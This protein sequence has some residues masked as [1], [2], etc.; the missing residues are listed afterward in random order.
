MARLTFDAVQDYASECG[1]TIEKKSKGYLLNGAVVPT[2]ARIIEVIKNGDLLNSECELLPV[3]ESQEITPKAVAKAL[4]YLNNQTQ[5]EENMKTLYIVRGCPGDGK[6]TLAHRLVDSIVAVAADDM[7]GLYVDGKYQQHLQ[8]QSHEWCM[9][10]IEG[11]MRGNIEEMAVHN[12]FTRIF[13]IK[14]Y[15]ELANKYG[16]SVHIIHSEAVLTAGGRTTD[17]H[18]VPLDVLASMRNG[19]E[20]WDT[21]PKLGITAKDIAEQ[22][23]KAK[24]YPDCIIF[25]MDGTIK[26]TKSGGA[27]PQTPDDF[28]ITKEFDDFINIHF[29]RIQQID[30]YIVSNQRG[31]SGGQKTEEFL[32]KEVTCLIEHLDIHY[33]SSPTKSYF[34]SKDYV[35]ARSWDEGRDKFYGN[36][37]KPSPAVFDLIHN[38]IQSN[39]TRRNYWII[40]DA[41]TDERSEDWQFAQN[42]QKAHPELN[43]VYIPIEL[44]AN[45]YKLHHT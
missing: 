2:L 3:V 27:F 32:D 42:C 36:F 30:S 25:D 15:I 24:A 40:G 23:E 4:S 10:Q 22:I 20:N 28:E 33:D 31:L 1:Y 26:R 6:T 16:Y 29:Q 7:P 21:L 35:F 8:K 38:L 45:I 41:H 39:N 17:T 14:P 19:W 18:N 34:A 13:Y 43:I 44:A 37:A 12:T 11:M 9:N 5:T